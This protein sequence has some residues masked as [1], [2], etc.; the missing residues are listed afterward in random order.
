MNARLVGLTGCYQGRSVSLDEGAGPLV[1]GRA[2]ASGVALPTDAHVS[3]KHAQVFHWNGEWYCSDL[4]STNGTFVDGQRIAPNTPVH[5]RRGSV[6]HIGSQEFRFEEI[7]AAVSLAKPED[8]GRAGWPE[9]PASVD[10]LPPAPTAARRFMVRNALA[11]FDR[12]LGQAMSKGWI[13]IQEVRQLRDLQLRS[14]LTDTDTYPLRAG[15]IVRLGQAILDGGVVTDREFEYLLCAMTGLGT[16]NFDSRIG[17]VY[18]PVRVRQHAHNVSLGILPSKRIAISPIRLDPGETLHW[19]TIAELLEERV[20]NSG[21]VSGRSGVSFR[22][23]KG[24]RWYVGG[25]KGHY[26][27]ERAMVPV[28]EGD[29]VITSYR[30]VFLGDLK[31]FDVAWDK[32]LG[33]EPY[34]DGI[35]VLIQGRTRPPLLRYTPE[36][37][38]D[39]EI[40]AALCSYYLA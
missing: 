9:A 26:V 11:Q 19:E 38:D 25:T 23:A 20:V 40:V 28:A 17:A 1:I 16:G 21:W 6:I 14:G 18:Q 36:C 22:I 37:A 30:I 24:V 32:V 39:A 12:A 29:L 7:T 35:Q 27:S 15:A 2:P 10:A 4:G 5:L 33:I 31:A 13:E 3:S 34:A 8:Y